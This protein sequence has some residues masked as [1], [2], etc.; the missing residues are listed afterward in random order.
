MLIQ[1]SDLLR[2]TADVGHPAEIPLELELE[3][4]R[5]YLGIQRMRFGPRLV[6]REHV[7]P[8]AA[9]A[10]VPPLVLQP[11]VENA[12]THGLGPRRGPGIVEVSCLRHGEWV[13]LSVSDDGVGLPVESPVRERVGIGNTRARLAAMFGEQWRLD[14]SPR[15][16]GGGGTTVTIAIPFRA[17]PGVGDAVPGLAAS[18]SPSHLT[19]V[20]QPGVV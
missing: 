3:R 18:R 17:A 12:L 16:A 1:L 11:I 20:A 15:T 2:L 10:L 13:V 6:I 8:A 7:D 19:A 14:M 5:L 9:N 4:L